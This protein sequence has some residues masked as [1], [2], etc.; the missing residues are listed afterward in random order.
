MLKWEVKSRAVCL[1]FWKNVNKI[2]YAA[3]DHLLSKKRV[4]NASVM[5]EDGHSDNSETQ[6]GGFFVFHF[7][8][9]SLVQIKHVES[10]DYVYSLKNISS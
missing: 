5:Q 1:I 6:V 7:S 9:L 10:R 2:H 3:A 4:S 8:L